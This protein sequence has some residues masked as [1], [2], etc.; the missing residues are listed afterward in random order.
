M[1]AEKAVYTFTVVALMAAFGVTALYFMLE[2]V[3][4]RDRPEQE[5]VD[6]LILCPEGYTAYRDSSCFRIVA[7]A[8]NFDQSR[9]NCKETGGDLFVVRDDYDEN[10]LEN[11]K[12]ATIAWVGLKQ[13]QEHIDAFSKGGLKADEDW[14]WVDGRPFDRPHMW[15]H[16]EP[17]D[18][19]G[20][21]GQHCGRLDNTNRA[22]NSGGGLFNDWRCNE[23][24]A[25][26]ICQAPKSKYRRTH[27]SL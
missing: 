8:K 16:N 6:T 3:K 18:A 9:Q 1:N 13:T 25:K 20:P 12:D 24:G 14:E 11:L 4:R 21:R 23:P 19:A 10:F 22:A 5:S 17:D 27:Q 7:E 15:Q 26:H 2:L